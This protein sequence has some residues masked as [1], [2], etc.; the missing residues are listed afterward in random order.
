MLANQ[1][2]LIAVGMLCFGLAAGLRLYSWI[3]R[4]KR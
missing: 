2:L 1:V 3:F 4:L